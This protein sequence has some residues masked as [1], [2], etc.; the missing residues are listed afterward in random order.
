MS[1]PDFHHY[2]HGKLLLT[3]EYFI[4]DGT[5]GLAVPTKR[6]QHLRLWQN[7]HLGEQL[8]WRALDEHGQAWLE[9]SL[10]PSWW[11]TSADIDTNHP[12]AFLLKALRQAVNLRP[13]CTRILEGARVETHLEFNRRWGLGSSSTLVA[14]LAELLK[15]DPYQLLAGSFGGSGYDLACARAEGPILFSRE[16]GSVAV[17]SVAWQPDWLQQT[18][19]VYRNQKQDSREGIRA[20]RE[21]NIRADD[22]LRIG[23]ITHALLEESL[24]L[25]TAAQLL[26]EHEAIVAANLGLTTIQE[27][28][29]LD[30]PGQLKS[31]GA[32]GG[33][34]FWALSEEN[35]EKVTAYFN[36]R[37]FSTVIPY[38]QMVL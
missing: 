18:C 23:A 10:L 5:P 1:Q 16:E 4:L 29:F 17:K 7:D 36:D 8:S 26:Q 6:G 37:G 13:G 38:N 15:V 22:R 30:F 27:E 19:F 14:S 28:F 9:A 21:A 2:A 11:A 20:Y 33:D 32:W 34:F 35:P 24:H 31:L 3:G 12:H 25:R